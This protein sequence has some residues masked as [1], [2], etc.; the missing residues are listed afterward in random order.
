MVCMHTHSLHL[1]IV[2]GGIGVIT[3]TDGVAIL[4]MATA[5]TIGMAR[6]GASAGAAGTAVVGMAVA[7]DTIITIIIPVADGIPVVDT[8]EAVHIGAMLIPIDVLMERAVIHQVTEFQVLQ[9]R[10][11]LLL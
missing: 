11:V 4:T 7:G 3:P 1:E 9:H 2:Y 8:G 10:V 5:G 6:A